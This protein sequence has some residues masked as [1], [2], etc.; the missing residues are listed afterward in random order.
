M[1]KLL[2]SFLATV[3]LATTAS[4]ASQIG[5]L[6]DGQQLY[7]RTIVLDANGN[8]V[9][10]ADVNQFKYSVKVENYEITEL[11]FTDTLAGEAGASRFKK[12]KK[13]LEILRSNGRSVKC[14]V[15]EIAQH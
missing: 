4:A 1:K 2:N 13:E 3:L 14:S 6:S 8:G 15:K 12:G 10:A 5:C 9:N 7:G 11:K